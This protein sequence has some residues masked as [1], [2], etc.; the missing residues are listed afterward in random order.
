MYHVF[1]GRPGQVWKILL[2]PAGAI[3][4][5]TRRMYKGRSSKFE[6]NIAQRFAQERSNSRSCV[7]ERRAAYQRGKEDSQLE[8]AGCAGSTFFCCQSASFLAVTCLP[9]RGQCLPDSACC[10]CCFYLTWAGMHSA[11]QTFVL[12]TDIIMLWSC[13]NQA[14]ELIRRIRPVR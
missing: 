2:S 1:R 14:K 10:S 8:K 12:R 11:N 4:K 7:L 3:L 9:Y 6:K 13:F 5:Q